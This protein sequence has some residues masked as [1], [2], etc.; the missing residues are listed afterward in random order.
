MICQ[1]VAQ[2]ASR[3]SWKLVRYIKARTL[4]TSAI[5]LSQSRRPGKNASRLLVVVLLLTSFLFQYALATEPRPAD[6][7]Q[8][9]VR[10]DLFG[11]S[12]DA[13]LEDLSRRV[14]RY[15]VE[16]ADPD[17]GLVLDRARADGSPHDETHRNVASIAATGFGLT[18]LCI[19]AERGWMNRSE[20]RM[21]LRSALEFFADRAIQEHGWFYHWMDYKSG[22]R[23]W[24]SE[25]SSIDTALLLAGVLTARQYFRDD[26]EV[27]R[28]ATRIYE[29]VDFQW[30]LN[31]DPLLLSH[32]WKPGSGFLRPRW[33]TF[34]EDTILYLLAIGSPTHSISPRSWYA[35]WRDRYR[36]E[37]Y[38]YFTSIG[39]PLFMHQYAHAWIDFRHRR[40]VK[41][42]H[43]DYFE[44]SINATLAHRAFCLNLAPEF[45]TFGPNM[46]GITASGSVKGYVVWGGPPRDPQIDGT[47]V[48]SAAGGSLMFTPV[49]SI[50]ALKTMRTRFGDRI[51]GR[52]GFIDAFNPSTGWA[53]RDV[54]GINL[55][56]ILLSAENARTENVWRWFMKNREIPR[57]MDL[58]GLRRSRKDLSQSVNEKSSEPPYV[59][60][61]SS[62]GSQY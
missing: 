4:I 6:Y 11:Q 7:E 52:Y 12:D 3:A 40:E 24:D 29:R 25:V 38:K 55:G 53:D 37:G 39:V 44:N 57:A 42:D 15:F 31:G 54:I 19:A 8:N 21:R 10:T 46:W 51:Y 62:V 50:A 26:L 20:A 18:A 28:L 47:I 34:S 1:S 56:I 33:D 13:F 16:Q 43:I 27:V 22:E 60:R 49:L 17:T 48:P 9:P 14:F 2:T 61:V 32:G 59:S 45:S 35:L 41:G 30:M 5:D 36:Y 58:I 23:R